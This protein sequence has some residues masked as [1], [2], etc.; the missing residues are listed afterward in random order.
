MGLALGQGAWN[1]LGFRRLGDGRTGVG[2]VGD[3]EAQRP[4]LSQAPGGGGG[5]AGAGARRAASASDTELGVSG[6]E[7][8]LAGKRLYG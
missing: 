7:E 5:R 6:E 3:V 8:R 2:P 1:L 4:G